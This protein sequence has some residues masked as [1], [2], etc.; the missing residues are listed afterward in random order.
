M[1][2]LLEKKNKQ[3]NKRWCWLRWQHTIHS[4]VLGFRS[5]WLYLAACNLIWG[6]HRGFLCAISFYTFGSEKFVC[7]FL[8]VIMV[9]YKYLAYA[10]WQTEIIPDDVAVSAE[11]MAKMIIIIRLGIM[12]IFIYILV[13]FINQN[14]Y[15]NCWLWINFNLGR[16]LSKFFAYHSRIGHTFLHEQQIRMN[17]H[18]AHLK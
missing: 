11:S 4:L 10:F 16:E 13:L 12:W 14:Y 1:I 5:F 7:V 6:R 9:R 17:H 8:D 15:F 18:Y 3:T 2:F